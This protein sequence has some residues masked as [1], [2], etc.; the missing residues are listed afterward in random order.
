M[1]LCKT[2]KRKPASLEQLLLQQSN[3]TEM[4]QPINEPAVAHTGNVTL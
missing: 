2:S 1:T 3:W 4:K